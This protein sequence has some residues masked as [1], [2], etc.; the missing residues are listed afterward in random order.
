MEKRPMALRMPNSSEWEKYLA[1]MAGLKEQLQKGI[2]SRQ[3]HSSGFSPSTKVKLWQGLVFLS[4]PQPN[5]F[6]LP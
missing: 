1:A 5:Y 6:S 4:L 2:S 3:K